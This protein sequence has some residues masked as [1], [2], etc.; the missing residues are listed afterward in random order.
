[1]SSLQVQPIPNAS[2][3]IDCVSV[4]SPMVGQAAVAAGVAGVIR[5]FETLSPNELDVI[6]ALDLGLSIV[7]YSR[8]AGWVATAELGRSDAAFQMTK[9][10]ALGLPT[11]GLSL[12]CDLEQT[13]STGVATLQYLDA[14]GGY[15]RTHDASG[16][17]YEGAG[18]PLSGRSLYEVA[19]LLGYWRS[20]SRVPEP[21]CAYQIVQLYAEPPETLGGAAV[22]YNFTC[23]D[24]KGRRATWIKFV[25]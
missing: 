7:G 3:L 23:Q 4:I 15:T 25:R 12:W 9:T 6:F 5:Y 11:S 19:D 21:D 8:P 1:M 22:D 2:R 10:V 18:Q 14:F 13:A 24:F 17:L 20:M 16:S